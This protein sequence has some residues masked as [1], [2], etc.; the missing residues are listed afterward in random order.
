MGSISIDFDRL[1]S[2]EDQETNKFNHN[3]ICVGTNGTEFEPNCI[4]ERSGRCVFSHENF[5]DSST[6]RTKIWI[7]EVETMNKMSRH[8]TSIFSAHLK[9]NCFLCLW[10]HFPEQHIQKRCELFMNSSCFCINH[11]EVFPFQK[12]IN[13]EQS[14][15]ACYSALINSHDWTSCTAFDSHKLRARIATN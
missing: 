1:E 6:Y 4:R 14:N 12:I 5:D 2:L 9:F 8:I 3:L 11:G 10:I 7:N 15:T 13:S